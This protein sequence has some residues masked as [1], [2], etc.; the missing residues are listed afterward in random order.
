MC[1]VYGLPYCP[2]QQIEI[3]THSRLKCY[4]L[5]V[6]LFLNKKIIQEFFNDLISQLNMIEFSLF[7]VIMAFILIGTSCTLLIPLLGHW[8]FF[9]LEDT[10][11]PPV[12]MGLQSTEYHTSLV[13]SVSVTVPTF[14]ELLLR[15]CSNAKMEYVLPNAI[16]L[17]SLSIPDLIM[18]TYVRVF[19][20][21]NA[22]NYLLK[23][24]LLLFMW[25][26]STFI[27][28]Y[29]GKS[30]SSKG[31]IISFVFLSLGRIMAFYQVYYSR[32]VHEMLN[33]LGTASDLFAYVIFI[34]MAIKWYLYIYA[35][36]KFVTMTNH[37]YLCNIYV[38][39]LA[40]TLVECM[41]TN[42]FPRAQSIGTI[43]ESSN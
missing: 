1:R 3:T 34:V 2:L 38:T 14:L 33:I 39:A 21:L 29:G 19:L 40:I 15:I 9:S 12:I 25:V 8:K 31:I 42:F 36:T 23:V 10:D 6:L 28:K 11:S 24:R 5:C 7:H 37:Q 17:I 16:I 20:D 22:L 30:W 35:E 43:G 4:D 13:V 32:D 18:L 26:T 41:L 27:R